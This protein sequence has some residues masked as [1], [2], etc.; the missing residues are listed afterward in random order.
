V[1]KATGSKTGGKPGYSHER[2]KKRTVPPPFPRR[3]LCRT[4]LAVKGPLRR[5]KPAPLTVPGRSRTR[6]HYEGKGAA[7]FRL[8]SAS[9]WSAAWSFP[10]GGIFNRYYGEF[11]ARVDKRK[12]ELRVS[13]GPVGQRSGSPAPRHCARRKACRA[14]GCCNPL[15]TQAFLGLT[16]Q[17]NAEKRRRRYQS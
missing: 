8:L 17:A 4:V 16:E 5:A 12:W 3:R 13:S 9:R 2:R 14:K 7:E 6:F 10:G 1:E 15:E 11:S